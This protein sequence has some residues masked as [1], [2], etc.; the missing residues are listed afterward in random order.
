MRDE[1]A[2]RVPCWDCGRGNRLIDGWVTATGTR[3]LC[4]SCAFDR[5]DRGEILERESDRA[6][7][8]EDGHWERRLDEERDR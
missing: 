5:A 6:E 4:D 2:E 3:P 8:L 7:R 1:P